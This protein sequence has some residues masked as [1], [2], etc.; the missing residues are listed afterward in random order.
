[1][2][3]FIKIFRLILLLAILS[4]C[5]QILQTVDLEL[6]SEDNVTQEEFNVVEQTLTI[7]QAKKQ[8]VSNYK[9]YVLQAGR[10]NKAKSILETIAIQSKFPDANIV[11][12]YTIGIGDTLK[13]SRLI[14]NYNLK[15]ESD[16]KW[17]KNVGAS[18]Y[19]LGVGDNLALILIKEEKTL[20]FGPTG[21]G[22]DDQRIITEEKKD[23]VLETTGR[24]GSDGSV[25]LLEIGR[26]EARGKTLNEVRSEVRNILIRNGSS[27]R[28]QLEI[29]D[30]KSQKAYLTVNGIS[31]VQILD[32]QKTTL[33]D[34]LTAANVGFKP[35]I[36]TR[37]NL[38]RNGEEY[39]IS[40]RSVFDQN[41]PN[42]IINDGDHI[43]VEDSST[44]L[45]SSEANVDHDGYVVFAG[46][47]RIKAFGLTL[48]ELRS[49]ISSQISKIPGSEVIFQIEISEFSSQ[50]A[51]ISIPGKDGGVIPITDE[52]IALDEIL[53]DIGLTISGENVIRITLQRQNESYFFSLDDLLNPNTQKVYLQPNDRVTTEILPYKENKVFILGGVNPQIYKINP[54]NRETLADVLFTSGGPLS[55]AKAKRSEVYLL[56]GNNPVVAYHLDAQSPTRLIV[57]DAMELRPNDILYVAEQPIISFNR[58]LATIVPLRILLRDIQDE[59]I[60]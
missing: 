49:E 19:K 48:D 16:T 52:P 5:S 30:F 18:S 10:G 56:R 6:N 15:L 38:R 55:S 53:T 45:S 22:T 36:I 7:A 26:L 3:K 42:I 37:V 24:I 33:K 50:N 60:P 11:R 2:V 39:R 34:I 14:E 54:A 43:F 35:G 58:A 41:A 20:S 29:V 51:L 21:G 59:N 40:L 17:P 4:N 31:G 47:G 32:Y 44:D 1:M 27:P 8:N 9:R 57:A 28:F 12:Q 23:I 25:L 13:L 46:I